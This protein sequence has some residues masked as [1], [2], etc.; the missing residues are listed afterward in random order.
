MMLIEVGVNQHIFMIAVSDIVSD[1]SATAQTAA[2][3]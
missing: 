3:F 2:P 1:E